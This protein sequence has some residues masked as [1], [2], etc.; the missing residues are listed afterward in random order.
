M[1][2]LCSWDHC[3]GACKL[4]LQVSLQMGQFGDKHTALTFASS[5]SSCVVARQNC[6]EATGVALTTAVHSF[7]IKTPHGAKWE[8]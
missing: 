3:N 6:C 1:V 8:Y 2:S 4:T 5:R 7:Q